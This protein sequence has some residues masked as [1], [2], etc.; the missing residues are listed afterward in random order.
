MNY[1]GLFVPFS[2][3]KRFEY[4]G[5]TYAVRKHHLDAQLAQARFVNNFIL[6][7]PVRLYEIVSSIL[8]RTDLATFID[9]L[10]QAQMYRQQM[11][12]YFEDKDVYHKYRFMT[13]MERGEAPDISSGSVFTDGSEGRRIWDELSEAIN[14]DTR[15]PLNLDDFPRF[16]YVTESLGEGIY[17]ILPY[18]AGLLL[19][20]IATVTVTYFLFLRYDVR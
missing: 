5:R 9:F 15:P 18:I 10:N 6:F 14:Y 7:S 19:I 13:I 8:A 4:A 1:Y 2:E 16:S 20:I 11:L 17:R 3:E 12:D